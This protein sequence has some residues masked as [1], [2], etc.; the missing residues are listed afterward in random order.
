MPRARAAQQVKLEL[1]ITREN[2]TAALSATYGRLTPFANRSADVQTIGMPAAAGAQLGAMLRPISTPL[3]MG[4]FEPEIADLIA[5]AFRESGFT[6]VISG[7]ATA[8]VQ[9]RPVR[10]ASRG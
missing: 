2:L 9:A 4:G 1:P 3:L 5:G 7:S 8:E 6:P 10:A